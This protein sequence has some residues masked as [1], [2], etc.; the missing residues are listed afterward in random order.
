MAY[1]NA[2]SRGGRHE[3]NE[4]KTRE[5]SCERTV[6]ESKGRSIIKQS[7]KLEEKEETK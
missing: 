7:H 5:R 2:A 3:R 6:S 1:N 4:R